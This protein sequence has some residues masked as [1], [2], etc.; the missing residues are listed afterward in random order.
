MKRNPA[1]MII[2]GPTGLS[3]IGAI[4]RPKLVD[5]A[6]VPIDTTSIEFKFLAKLAEN[7][8]TDATIKEFTEAWNAVN[9]WKTVNK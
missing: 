7:P 4:M 8:Q 9:A 6:A 2:T 5:I 1:V 3:M